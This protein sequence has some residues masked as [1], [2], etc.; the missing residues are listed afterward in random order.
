MEKECKQREKDVNHFNQFDRAFDG[1]NVFIDPAEDHFADLADHL[2]LDQ[3][4]LPKEQVVTPVSDPEV[5]LNTGSKGKMSIQDMLNKL[6]E[7][8]LELAL[9]E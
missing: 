9:K 3:E 6:V 2:E 1:V 4:D 7:Q 5:I 8:K